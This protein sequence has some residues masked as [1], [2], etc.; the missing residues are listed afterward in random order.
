MAA[1][2]VFFDVAGPD[3]ALLVRFYARLFQWEIAGHGGFAAP[4]VS[5]L[6][7]TIRQDPAGKVIYVGV[8][9]VT[10]TLGDIAASGGTIV[11]PRFEVPGIVVLGLFDDPAGNR[12]GLVEMKDGKPRVP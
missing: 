11:A 7:A 4:V 10:A 12:M 1:P 8:A 9:D 2:I 6:P 3:Q 5:P